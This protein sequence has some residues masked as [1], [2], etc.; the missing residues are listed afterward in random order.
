MPDRPHPAAPEDEMAELFFKA[1]VAVGLSVILAGL[2]DSAA[3]WLLELIER[4]C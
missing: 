1:D 4:T 3:T 2:S